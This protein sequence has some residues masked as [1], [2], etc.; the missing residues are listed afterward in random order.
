VALDRALDLF[1]ERG[2]E[3]TSLAALTSAMEIAPPSLYAAF[4]SKEQ[5]FFEAI[6]R[7]GSTTGQF[8]AEALR[9]APTAREAIAR[10]LFEA[11]DAFTSDSKRLGCPVV[12]A[13]TNCAPHSSAIERAMRKQRITSE[14]AI[15]ARIARGVEDGELPDTTNAADL[16]KFYAAVFQGMSVQARDG[17]SRAELEHVATM[18]LST[19]PAEADS[20][21]PPRRGTTRTPSPK[22]AQSR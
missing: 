3:G 21:P 17:A 11:A 22:A 1:C 9:D 14:G 4:G 8:A 19:W 7:Y 2:Y 12:T 20:S 6:A 18:A 13:A 15:R 10:L 5:L 16:A